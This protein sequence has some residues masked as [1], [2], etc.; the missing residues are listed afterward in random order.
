MS[1][2]LST[3]VRMSGKTPYHHGVNVNSHLKKMINSISEKSERKLR[4]KEAK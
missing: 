3:L 1:L 4:R 2:Q